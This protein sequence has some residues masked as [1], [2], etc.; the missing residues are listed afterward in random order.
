[1]RGTRAREFIGGVKVTGQV[2][3]Q[4]GVKFGDGTT[5][6]SAGVNVKHYTFDIAAHGAS[7]DIDLPDETPVHL[8]G[9]C[10]TVG[11]RG[12]GQLD[13]IKFPNPPDGFLI[14]TGINSTPNGTVTHGFSS[15]ENT[16]IIQ[17][18]YNADVFVA[19]GTHGKNANN[20]DSIRVLNT[21]DTLRTVKITLIW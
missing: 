19:V 18:N 3:A 21:S 12:V 15:I 17:L 2:E 13:L 14:W 9:A 20:R 7:P 10:V 1:M 16:H 11:L 8:I 5:Q 6:T 4:G